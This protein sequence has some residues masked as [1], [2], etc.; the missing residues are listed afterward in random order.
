ML[1]VWHIVQD[2]ISP[3]CPH[4]SWWYDR[5]KLTCWA[6][7][8]NSSLLQWCC[9]GDEVRV[10]LIRGGHVQHNHR[11]GRDITKTWLSV[12]VLVYV[13]SFLQVPVWQP[14]QH[15][16][17]PDVCW[18]GCSAWAVSPWVSELAP[19][20]VLVMQVSLSPPEFSIATEFLRS[21][22]IRLC[23]HLC[24]NGCEQTNIIIHS[25][26]LWEQLFFTV[27]IF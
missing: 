19:T 23:S 12:Q 25:K 11:P 18:I 16:H 21:E 7:N 27:E 24:C 22:T 9:L 2:Q 15:C 14:N 13:W 17:N 26:F 5:D 3:Y 10:F 6:Q 1:N 4:L 20:A 8:T